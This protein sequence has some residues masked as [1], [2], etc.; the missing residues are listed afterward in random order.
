MPS[1]VAGRANSAVSCPPDSELAGLL[2]SDVPGD[3]ASELS[4]HVQQCTACQTRL[5]RLDPS[6]LRAQAAEPPPDGA[7]YALRGGEEVASD[8]TT[9]LLPLGPRVPQ[10]IGHYELQQRIGRG[11]MGIVY[12]ARHTR[13]GRTVAVKLLPGLQFS[14]RTAIVRL[15][16]E[17][18]ATAKVEHENIV[19]ALD[20]GEHEGIDYL[21]TEYVEGL[22]LGRLIT[23]CGPVAIADACEIIRQ[24]A[25]GLAH[26][27]SRGLVHRDIKPSNVM[28]STDGVVKILDLGLARLLEGS[29]DDAE[30][31]H[32][33]FLLGTA[34]YIAPEQIDNPRV[35]D[36]RSDLYSLGCTFYKLLTGQAPFAG[37]G[38]S[39]VSRKLDAH[40]S[41]QIP[42]LE[43]L[44]PDGSPELVAILSRFL[45]KDP[46]QRWQQ[47]EEVA[48]A[49]A[50]LSR[51][52]RSP[53][54]G[55]AS[56]DF[57][58]F[59]AAGASES[60][61]PLACYP[62]EHR[63]PAQHP[64]PDHFSA[65]APGRRRLGR[66]CPWCLRRFGR[67]CLVWCSASRHVWSAKGSGRGRQRIVGLTFVGPR[68]SQLSRPATDIYR[69][70]LAGTHA[71]HGQAGV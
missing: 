37:D 30:A 58:R 27:E 29:F 33:G 51:G 43:S 17:M 18:T 47:A 12:R 54:A 36:S 68:K 13:L 61:R 16:R 41:D 22:D 45:A 9:T 14:D 62:G 65:T 66:R 28:L 40:R 39:V 52:S 48:D 53:T 64:A 44:R 4:Q 56:I 31:T 50:P 1:S 38:L 26:I 59:A 15:Q 6:T 10:R 5:T 11:G 20:A 25:L 71:L 19:A 60:I 57:G 32:S 70:N 23:A 24:A 3:E 8:R 63:P 42:P 67:R 46:S 69:R 35:A 49:L 7:A 2:T 34:D 55:G 21:V